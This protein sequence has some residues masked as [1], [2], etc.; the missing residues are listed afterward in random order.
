MTHLEEPIRRFN[1]SQIVNHWVMLVSFVGLVLTGFPQKYS[2]QEW[3]KGI[4]LIIG[5]VERVRWL[6]HVFG[7]LMALQLVWHGLDVLWHW[8]VRRLPLTMIPSIDDVRHF[9][10]QIQFN[11]DRAATPP[12][13]PRYTFA[14]K[15]EYLA[16]IWGTALMVVTGIVLLYPTRWLPVPGEFVLAAK[17]A[18]GGEA[19]LALLSILTWHVYFVHVR[20]RNWSIFNGSLDVHAYAEEHALELDTIRRGEVAAPAPLAAWRVA[21]FAV[22]AVIATALVAALWLWLRGLRVPIQTIIAGP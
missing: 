3:A 22:V 14:E 8:L 16:L 4:I 13:M 17:A 6:H 2:G 20:H 18:H 21:V 10:Q 12:R 7:T 15:V 1:R 9:W 19:L 11:L 5:G